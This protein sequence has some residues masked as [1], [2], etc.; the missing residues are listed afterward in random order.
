LPLVLVFVE[1]LE[2]QFIKPY[3]TKQHNPN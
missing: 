2:Y 1:Y 3:W